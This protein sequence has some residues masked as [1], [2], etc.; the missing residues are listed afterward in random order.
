MQNLKK[1]YDYD[2]SYFKQRG[3]SKD[4]YD[5][6]GLHQVQ[7]F[8]NTA[9]EVPAFPIYDLLGNQV[10]IG[11]RPDFSNMK[12]Y[13]ESYPKTKHLYGLNLT[14]DYIRKTGR[15]FITEGPF[16]LYALF[17]HGHRNVVSLLGRTLSKWQLYLL[18]SFTRNFILA[19]DY[20]RAGLN[21]SKII[22]PFIEQTIPD[23]LVRKIT[24]APHKDFSEKFSNASINLLS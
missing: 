2:N 9:N 6:F 3:V 14:Q 22:K 20:D 15:V 19:L 11:Y 4:T 21:A 16:D 5:L 12:Y 8:F 1:I 24:S 23:A 10:S 7:G 18:A 17:D 13:Y